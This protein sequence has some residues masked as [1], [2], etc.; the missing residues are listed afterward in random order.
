MKF[1]TRLT[2]AFGLFAFLLVILFALLLIESLT[3]VEDQMVLSLLAQEADYLGQRYLE[4]P[5][6]VAMPDLEQLKGYLSGDPRLPGWL[7]NYGPGFHQ[8]DDFHVLVR[9]LD[10]DR[11]VYLVYDETSG[12]L[13]RHKEA[14]LLVLVLLVLIVSVVGIALG[15]YQAS[16]LARP[17]NQLAEQVAEVDAENPQIMPLA[18]RDEVGQLSRAYAELVDRLGRFNQREKAFTRYASHELMTPISILNNNLELLRNENASEAMRSR[19]I[20]RLGEAARQMQRQVEV[21][22]MLARGGKFEPGERPLDWERLRQAMV[23]QFARVSVNWT[24]DDAPELY[25]S[26]A[27]VQT[28]LANIF[29]NIEKHG[30]E[31]AGVFRASLTLDRTRLVVTNPLAGATTRGVGGDGF[32]LEINSKLCEVLG[33]QFSHRHENAAFIVTVTFQ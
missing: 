18:S 22:L 10:A 27:V 25:A 13:D 11:L 14:M 29:G 19:A 20:D 7:Q 21:F 12:V 33:W 15:V 28:I 24:I 17:I 6:S 30:V 16:I 23:T 4:N 1:K 26:E 31:E 5:E 8:N 32:G 2:V 3:E 9:E